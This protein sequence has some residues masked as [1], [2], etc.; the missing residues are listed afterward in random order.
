MDIL[1]LLPV[2]WLLFC[3]YSVKV[4]FY[5]V[6]FTVEIIINIWMSIHFI[7]SWVEP[8]WTNSERLVF[9][10]LGTYSFCLLWIKTYTSLEFII[11]TITNILIIVADTKITIIV[12]IISFFINTISTIHMEDTRIRSYFK[13]IITVACGCIEVGINSL[14]FCDGCLRV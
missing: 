11:S 14:P 8:S 13:R 7:L 12:K 9:N 6:I 2:F 5:P 3:L 4:L 10:M 1:F